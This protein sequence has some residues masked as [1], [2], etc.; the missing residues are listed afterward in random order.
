MKRITL[1]LGLDV[2]KDSITIGLAAPEQSACGSRITFH[3]PSQL[4][5]GSVPAEYS[6]DDTLDSLGTLRHCRPAAAGERLADARAFA[7][8]GHGGA[9]PGGRA[10]ADAGCARP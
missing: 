4:A 8:G 10:D 5:N 1:Y 6:G 7:G 9:E 3:A 2:H